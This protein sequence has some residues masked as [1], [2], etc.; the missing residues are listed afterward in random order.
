MATVDPNAQSA[1]EGGLVYVSDTDPGLRRKRA[2]KGFAYVDA[3]GR[4]VRDKATLQRIRALAI[5]PAYRDVWICARANGHLQATG[6]DA[7]GRK[8][9]RYHPRWFEVRDARKFDRIV[10]FGRALPHLRR[11]LRNDLAQPGLPREKVTAIVV[12]ILADTM[13]RV[14]NDEYAR[15]NNSFGLTTLRNRHVEFLQGGRARLKFRGKSGQEHEIVLDDA[16]LAKLVRR[17]QQLPG[18]QLFQYQDEDGTPQPVDSGSVNAYLREAM[19]SDF[20][21]KDFRT[22]GGTLSAVRLLADQP[23][24]LKDNGQPNARVATSICNTVV[25]RVAKMLRNTPAVCRKAYIDPVVF[26][27]WKDGRLHRACNGARGPRQWEQA[28]LRLLRAAR[29]GTGGKA[30]K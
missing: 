15:G 10:A 8:Q 27:A 6:R 29:R 17:I 19:G 23:V 22:W 13:V 28:G 21:A 12:A 30:A 2:G 7:R 14:G 1:A 3:R 26:E 24:P 18:Q 25:A 5:P 9:Y 20:T 4:T 16:Q 11:T